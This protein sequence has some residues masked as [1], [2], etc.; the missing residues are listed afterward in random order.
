MGL[1]GQSD[2]CLCFLIVEDFAQ[3]RINL[4]QLTLIGSQVAIL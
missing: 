1:K 4:P 2:E 3:M